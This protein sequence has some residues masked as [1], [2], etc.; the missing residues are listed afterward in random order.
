M[1]RF[2]DLRDLPERILRE[3]AVEVV[4]EGENLVILLDV[5]FRTAQQPT[6]ADN[7]HLISSNYLLMPTSFILTIY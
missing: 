5:V 2:D 6:N 7:V 4:E 3:M 1:P